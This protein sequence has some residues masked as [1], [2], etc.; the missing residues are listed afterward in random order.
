MI[1]A[2]IETQLDARTRLSVGQGEP[3]STTE[4]AARSPWLYAAALAAVYLFRRQ[5]FSPGGLMFA[6]GFYAAKKVKTGQLFGAAMQGVVRE[7][8]TFTINK[9]AGELYDL[10]RDLEGAPRYMESIQSVKLTGG[11]TSHWVMDLPGGGTLEW[12]SELT[13]QEPGRRLAWRSIGETP[14]PSAGQVA[15]EPAASGRGTVVRVDQEFLLPG[16][17]LAATMG[18]LFSRTPGGFTRENL[19]HFKQLA[20][21]GEIPTTKGQPHGP[22][23]A[24]TK[25]TQAFTGDREQQNIEPQT[26]TIDHDIERQ[27]VA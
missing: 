4:K 8:A 10:W 17:K 23:S 6:T 7:Q 2:E 21:A 22:R 5:I 25:V 19:R 16:G 12:D 9:P 24:T 1:Q 14:V 3:Q 11:T 26:G 15:F 27:E 20:E 18:G 13:A